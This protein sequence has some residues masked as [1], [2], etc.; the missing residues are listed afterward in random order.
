MIVCASGQTFH[1]PVTALTRSLRV[2]SM[3]YWMPFAS[4]MPMYAKNM[5]PKHGFHSTCMQK[6]HK[7]RQEGERWT[8]LNF[9]GWL[10]ETLY[11]L[12][13]ART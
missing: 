8:G 11:L 6:A 1:E 9:G 3:T 7:M 4:S 12:C 2:L 5:T 10:G 13:A